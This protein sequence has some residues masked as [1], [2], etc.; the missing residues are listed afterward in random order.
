MQQFARSLLFI[1][2]SCASFGAFAAED[3]ALVYETHCAS[4]HDA[5]VA[6]TPS[7]K[8][9]QAM[10]P[11]V[12]VRS[13]ETGAMRVIG[14]WN[15]TGPKRVAVAEFLSGKTYDPNW[16]DSNKNLCAK[17]I[18]PSTHAFARP[19]WNGWA[20]DDNNTRFQPGA[21]AGIRATDLAGLELKWVFA[22][23]GETIVESQPAVIDGRLYTGS[24]SGMFYALDATSGCTYWTFQ[25]GAPIKTA[26]RIE[27]IG[28]HKRLAVFFGDIAGWIYALDAVSGEL[29]WKIRSGGHPSARLVGGFQYHAGAL[30]LGVSS[31]E[32]GQS[33]DPTYPCCSFRGSI[34]K[35]DA[36]TGRVQWQT[37]TIDEVPSPQGKNK[38]GK[39]MLGPSGAAIWSA[40]TLDHKLGR[41][42]AATSDN[43][44]HPA[45]A[46]S[47]SIIAL[48]MDTG[49][50]E[51]IYQGLAG[52]V[53]NSAC[54]IDEDA[55]CPDDAGP[56]E[57]MGSS[58]MLITLPSGKR[59]LAAGQKTGILH[60]LDPDNGGK[61][62]W[63]KKLAEGGIL[64]GIEWGP[65]TDGKYFYV[66]KADVTW[67]DQR[68]V[69][70]DTEL[71]P[72]TGGG[73]VAV[74][75]ASGDIV[76][77]APPLSCEGRKSCSPGQTGAVTAIPGVVF[78]GSLSGV[79]QALDAQTGSVLWQY[80]T[81]KSYDA[82][83]GARAHGGAL[84]GPGPVVVDGWVY[85]TS[86]YAKFGGLPGNVLLA[87][88]RTK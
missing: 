29:I 20:V 12:I 28:E 65:A 39:D 51:W 25:A 48:S 69:S 45:T 52:D 9:L 80:D 42:Y 88:S 3:G 11:D 18:S 38:R 23:P 86:G 37:Y 31:L 66:A 6:R 4:C 1:G 75:A 70:A 64:G 53:W 56:D 21:M 82:V 74:D 57:D 54:H 10:S 50:I 58:P 34:L 17:P 61:L 15:L 85:V 84:D 47:D 22:F 87:F 7:R 40:V 43:Y 62:L 41:L 83:N 68:F 78:T 77:E 46:T 60:V 5:G 79:L 59:L 44:S 71:N 2:L 8:T 76:W 19:Y 55:N 14:Q 49:K 13:L 26:P 72:T 35:V 27:P 67:R 63:Q 81:V 33:M 36:A 30:Y 24:R 73:T 32:E 16:R